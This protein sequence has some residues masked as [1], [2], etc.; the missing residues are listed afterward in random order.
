ML[1][2][3][4]QSKGNANCF[5]VFILL[6]INRI[7]SLVGEMAF[8]RVVASHFAMG[9]AVATCKLQTVAW[10]LRTGDGGTDSAGQLSKMDSYQLCL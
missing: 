2:H 8:L 7:N 6:K 5:L 9:C 3:T 10:P 4:I 1:A